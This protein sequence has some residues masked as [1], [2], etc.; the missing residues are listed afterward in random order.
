MQRSDSDRR[1]LLV[2]AMGTLIALQPPAARLRTEL[3]RRFGIEVSLDQ[4]RAAI[5]AEIRYYRAHMQDGRDAASVQALRAR[6]ARAL[7]AA[8]PA[9][10]RLDAV[11]SDSMTETLLDSLQFSVFGDAHGALEAARARCWQVVVVSNWDQSLPEVLARLG[12]AAL[13]DRVVTS[14]VVGAGKP[15][16]AIFEFAL[17][18]AGVSAARAL[19]VGDSLEEDVVGARAAGIEAVWLNRRGC[20]NGPVPAGVTEISSL[21][22][23]A[24]RM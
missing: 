15:D 21:E 11:D 2:D 5:A 20:G 24:A 22:E 23:L 17:E 6:C 14:A 10:E 4:A 1:C 13:I 16:P 19:H 7:R 18:A 9:N 3:G 12:L 8:L